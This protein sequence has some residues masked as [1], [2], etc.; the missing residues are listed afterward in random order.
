MPGSTLV[1]ACCDR[2]RRILYSPATW[3]LVCEPMETVLDGI[4][5]SCGNDRLEDGR[6]CMFCGDLLTQPALAKSREVSVRVELDTQVEYAGFWLRFWAG[7]V[8]LAL[9]CL[10]A[11]FITV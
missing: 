11:L 1:D 7:T 6:F 4:C 3:N 2:N 8:D 10:G 9:E 5:A